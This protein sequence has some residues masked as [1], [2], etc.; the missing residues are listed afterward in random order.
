[1]TSTT[2][3][4]LTPSQRA[5]ILRSLGFKKLPGM[6]PYAPA[7]KRTPK[8]KTPR[9]KPRPIR[10]LTT[11]QT[12]PSISA[13]AHAISAPPSNVS[14]HLRH[15][16]PR[17]VRG[18]TFEYVNELEPTPDTNT[19]TNTASRKPRSHRTTPRPVRCLTDGLTFP[20]ITKAA[21]HYGIAPANLHSH[22]HGSLRH[23]ANKTFE[24]IDPPVT[25]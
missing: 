1:M 23:V 13:A 19:N 8:A 5:A 24:W 4:R 12:F 11:G 7:P 22:L 25:T 21:K 3:P 9:I 16:S 10:C 15:G 20:S 17:V 6:K 14:S 2:L 18:H